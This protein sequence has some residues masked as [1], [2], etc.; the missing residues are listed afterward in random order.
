MRQLYKIFYIKSGIRRLTD[1][2]SPNLNTFDGFPRNAV[3]H[4]LT[5]DDEIHI[6]PTHVQFSDYNKRIPIDFV[7]ESESMVGNPRRV[8]VVINTHIQSFIREHRNFR[9][10]QNAAEVTSDQQVLV[11]INYNT[12]KLSYRFIKTPIMD[13]Y[14]WE[15][16]YKTLWDNINSVAMK[17]SKQHFVIIKP[18]DDI[19][20]YSLL[21]TFSDKSG[22]DLFRIF[23]TDNKLFILNLFNFINNKEK[24]VMG[25]ITPEAMNKINIVFLLKD[26]RFTVLNLSYLYSWIKGNEN[27]TNTKNQV[28]YDKSVIER[29]LLKF[30]LTVTSISPEEVIEEVEESV[31]EDNKSEDID[32]DESDEELDDLES[33]NRDENINDYSSK[34]LSLKSDIEKEYSEK[35]KDDEID[36]TNL[37]QDLSKFIDDDLRLLEIKNKKELMKKGIVVKNNEIHELDQ[38][39]DNITPE[40]IENK[41]YSSVT[42]NQALKDKLKE[43]FDIGI[44]DT[45]SYRKALKDADKYETTKDPYGTNKLLKEIV[46]IKPDDLKIDLDKTKLKDSNTVFDKSML[47]STLKVYTDEYIDKHLHNDVLKMVG[48]LQK[49]G[50]IVQKHEIDVEHNAMENFELHRIELKPIDGVSSSVWMRLPIIEQDGSFIVGGNKYFL[51]KQRVD[52]PIRK[53]GPNDVSLSSYYGK[54]FV[55][56]ESK[57]S[58]STGGWVL[59]QINK[60]S[61]E[62]SEWIKNIV[63]G[64]VFDNDKKTP[65]IY[66]VISTQFVSMKAGDLNLFFDG[67]EPE[68]KDTKEFEQANK[69]QMTWCGYK[70]D[71]KD[72]K[73]YNIFVNMDNIFYIYNNNTMNVLG[74]IYTVLKLDAHKAPIRFSELSIFRKLVPVCLVL[75]YRIGLKRLI[76]LLRVKPRIVEPRKRLELNQDEYPIP[77]ADCTYIF[78]RK[79]QL[80]TIILAGFLDFAKVTKEYNVKEFEH[81]DVYLNLLS[82]KGLGAIYIREIDMLFDYFVD[83]ITEEILKQMNEPVT[84]EGLLVRASELLMTYYHPKN[85]DGA[86]TRVRGYERIAGMVY[87]EMT[88]SVRQFRSKNIS[89]R[90]KIDISPWKIWQSINEDPTKML[91]PEI[92]P[93]QDLKNDESLT[94]L[95]EGGRSKEGINKASRS[96][97]ENDIGVIS[98]ATVDSDIVGVNVYMS[99]D[100]TLKNLRGMKSDQ[101]VKSANLLSTSVLLAPCSMHDDMKRINFVNIQQSHTIAA[102]GYHPPYVRTGYE[103]I[104]AQRTNPL[105]AYCAKDDG[106]VI[107]VTDKGVI[108]EYKDGKR[109]G[110]SIG[111]HFGRSEG[112]VYPFDI[113]S[114]VKENQSFKTGDP[115]VYNT[116]FFEYDYLNPGQLILKNSLNA[117]V[118]LWET[119][120]T[121]E[122]SSAISKSLSE[123]L[124][125]KVTYVRNFVVSFKQNIHDVVKQG[126]SINPQDSLIIVEDEITSNLGSFGDKSIQ[127]LKNLSKQSLK[128]NHYGTVDRIEV[129]YHGEKETMTPS[130]KKL[131]D[132]SD[133]FISS[134][135]KSTNKPKYT[136]L[137]TDSYRVDGVPLGLNKAEIRFYITVNTGMGVADKIIYANQMKSVNSEVMDYQLYTEDGTAIDAVFGCLSIAA[138]NVMSPYIIGTTSTL[139]RLFAKE[140]VKRFK[141]GS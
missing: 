124:G 21:K 93:I 81:K 99:P 20:S 113:E 118:V 52:L 68:D 44:M 83:P 7:F 84:F 107:S 82:N 48:A 94:Y 26:N 95:G 108:I 133:L 3:Y 92:N 11:V 5:T 35:I 121:H 67:K 41:I 16:Y 34:N 110:L 91:V 69:S 23:N 79:D 140:A 80:A 37:S 119:K 127:T 132:Q 70:Y 25:S 100:P 31:D 131:A 61:F 1:L 115:I 135:A 12:L 8:P 90:S 50:V 88:A 24:S 89:G 106:T 55:S 77:F 65:Y 139:L 13:L 30:F 134:Q 40:E 17:T 136:G 59:K 128:S 51:R 72:K 39:E 29:S 43:S 98:E 4:H 10:I 109:I 36:Q 126:Q 73:N 114:A 28:Q 105:F 22:L 56:T 112:S 46:E 87:K 120:Q 123:K 19:P 125:T 2:L 86:Y 53:I 97:H 137:V 116:G 111:R 42:P 141:E 75:G 138:R 32:D 102:K 117:K 74:D 54:S 130:L 27:I 15:S 47:N 14:R 78:S 62:G 85:Y 71:I 33:I 60:A 45:A 76:T 38:V 129:F 101:D 49:G 103:T 57:T 96:Y 63:P 104:V 18:T 58:N 66:G 122:D 64:D 9:Y 6:D